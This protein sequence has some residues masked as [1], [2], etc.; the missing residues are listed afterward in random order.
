MGQIVGEIGDGQVGRSQLER[1][2]DNVGEWSVGGWTD[3][4]FRLSEG[5]GP[6]DALPKT[7]ILFCIICI[8]LS[9][10]T[11]KAKGGA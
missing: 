10:A 7:N 9:Y 2:V 6:D 4:N 1:S 11:L 5:G 8:F 3:L